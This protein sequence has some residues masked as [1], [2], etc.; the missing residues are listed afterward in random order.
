[1]C[2]R[3]RFDH[4]YNTH[5]HKIDPIDFPFFC[6]MPSP[7]AVFVFFIFFISFNFYLK[8]K[9]RCCS[10]YPYTL[11]V[12]LF[13]SFPPLSH[14][15]TSFVARLSKT[16][17]FHNNWTVVSSYTLSILPISMRNRDFHC[18]LRFSVKLCSAVVSGIE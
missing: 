10:D 11:C 17:N 1:M 15:L 12:F 4:Q 14:T 8:Y 13:S 9:M 5:A 3:Y 16:I 7:C 6:C 2:Q 18:I